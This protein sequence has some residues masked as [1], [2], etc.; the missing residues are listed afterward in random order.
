MTGPQGQPWLEMCE[1]A[2]VQFRTVDGLEATGEPRSVGYWS[3]NDEE[4]Q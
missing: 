3:N 4:S 2:K 1:V